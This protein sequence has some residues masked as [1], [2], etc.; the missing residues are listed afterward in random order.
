VDSIP[1]ATKSV[2][3]DLLRGVGFAAM[4]GRERVGIVDDE[5]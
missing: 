3:V 5:S 4:D 1:D 2:K